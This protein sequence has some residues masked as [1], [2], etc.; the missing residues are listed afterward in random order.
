MKLYTQHTRVMRILHGLEQQQWKQKKTWAEF[1]HRKS[2]RE[3]E[4]HWFRFVFL[5]DGEHGVAVVLRPHQNAH[6][7]RAPVVIICL[8]IHKTQKRRTLFSQSA[9]KRQRTYS[10]VHS[11]HTHFYSYIR[12]RARLREKERVNKYSII[13]LSVLA[14]R[15]RF[16]I[17]CV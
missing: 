13:F 16:C 15:T 2:G 10:N 1:K 9:R 14:A 3:R 5:G 6:N 7:F 8:K 17:P 12:V 11:A 4:R